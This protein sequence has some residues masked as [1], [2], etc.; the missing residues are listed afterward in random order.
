MDFGEAR[1]WY[2]G[3]ELVRHSKD[4]DTRYSMY[5]PKAVVEA[6]LSHH[7]GPYW[8]QTETYEALKVYIQMN[9]DGL[10]DAVIRMLAGESVPVD[11][12]GFANDM[13]S[14]HSADDVFSLLI[15]LGYLNYSPDTRCVRIPNKEVGEVYTTSIICGYLPDSATTAQGQTGGG[16]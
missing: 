7:Y 12:T 11:I 15:H 14:M 10:K 5:N 13:T 4:G 9:I 8:N 1:A 3:Y 6:M 16:D 2:D